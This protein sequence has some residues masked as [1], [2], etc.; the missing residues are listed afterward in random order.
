[1]S[2]FVISRSALATFPNAPATVS[3]NVNF[4]TNDVT[5]RI[6]V[7]DAALRRELGSTFDGLERPFLWQKNASGAYEKRYL[8]L[9]GVVPAS[10]SRPTVDHYAS[11]FT[12]N[13]VD[14]LEALRQGV[15]VGL[16]TNLGTVWLQQWGD[17]STPDVTG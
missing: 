13:G 10:G 12:G 11:R 9:Q 5:V 1:M 16:D 3:A 6:S 15:A 7:N 4:H 2:T 8:A 17:N 14:A